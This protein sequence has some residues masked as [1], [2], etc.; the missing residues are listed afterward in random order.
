MKKYF[1]ILAVVAA[2][3]LVSA[4]TQQARS[5][6]D[7]GATAP[8]PSSGGAAPAASCGGSGKG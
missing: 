7:S 5:T 8:A 3:G 1:A 2:L 6:G 4:C